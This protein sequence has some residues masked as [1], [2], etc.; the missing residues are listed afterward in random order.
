MLGWAHVATIRNS[1]LEQKFI[2]VNTIWFEFSNLKNEVI[3][4]DAPWHVYDSC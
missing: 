4:D 2:Q 3:G 1:I